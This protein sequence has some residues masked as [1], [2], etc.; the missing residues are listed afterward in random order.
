LKINLNNSDNTRIKMSK[1]KAGK[2]TF[3]MIKPNAVRSRRQH[4]CDFKRYLCSRF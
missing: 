3:T 1:Q 4:W 2:R